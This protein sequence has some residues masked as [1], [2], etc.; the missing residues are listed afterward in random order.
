MVYSGDVDN[1]FSFTFDSID[2]AFQISA[3]G[4]LVTK[5]KAGTVSDVDFDETPADGTIA[6]DST[7]GRTYF[8]YGGAWH[9]VNKTA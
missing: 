6:V 2:A 4:G 9:Y 8:R 7:N 3:N 1:Q 5:I